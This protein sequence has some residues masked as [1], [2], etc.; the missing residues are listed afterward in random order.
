[1]DSGPV[2]PSTKLARLLTQGDPNASPSHPSSPLNSIIF[3]LLLYI[4]TETM[5]WSERGVCN[6]RLTSP[7]LYHT[8]LCLC[9]ASPLVM[10]Y[11]SL[12]Y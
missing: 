2:R 3:F 5:T 7:L 1:M 10:P 11:K 8:I 4:F 9:L 12:V 6:G